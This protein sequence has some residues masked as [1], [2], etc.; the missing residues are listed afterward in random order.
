MCH[1][2]YIVLTAFSV[3]YMRCVVRTSSIL[4][5]LSSGSDSLLQQL[6]LIPG[7]KVY[8]VW[9]GIV[10]ALV[11]V[12]AWITCFLAG[13]SHFNSQVNFN[14]GSGGYTVLALLYI[15][16][17]VFLLDI[18]VSLRT[19]ILTPYGMVSYNVLHVL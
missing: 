7:S 19:A 4:V 11:I 3:Q 1:S 16:D 14:T 12:A 8:Y 15:I 9:R 2:P 17:L 10:A 5:V 6:V 13:F 18:V